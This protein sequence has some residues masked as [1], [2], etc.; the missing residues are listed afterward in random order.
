MDYFLG[1]IVRG[2]CACAWEPNTTVEQY[3]TM[4]TTI[5]VKGYDVNKQFIEGR[6]TLR[7]CCYEN[8]VAKNVMLFLDGNHD[9][10]THQP[11][12]KNQSSSISNDSNQG[13]KCGARVGKLDTTAVPVGGGHVCLRGVCFTRDATLLL[14]R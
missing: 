12:T 1:D 8:S 2:M 5:S 11:G 9:A 3:S 4:M 14:Q 10:M 6:L 7:N 13:R